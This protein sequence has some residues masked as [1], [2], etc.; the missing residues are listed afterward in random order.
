MG[1]CG[2]CHAIKVKQLQID[3]K[4]KIEAKDFINGYVKEKQIF[5]RS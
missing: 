5:F 3:G 2:D 1:V 4:P